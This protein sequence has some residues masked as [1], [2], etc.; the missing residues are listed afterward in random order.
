VL[1]RIG[2]SAR[3]LEITSQLTELL[4]REEVLWRQRSHV[5]WLAAGDKNTRFFH[6]CAS[7]LRKKW[8]TKL[9]KE[10]GSLESGE[11]ELDHMP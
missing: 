11:E 1:D 10:D 8:I 6:L 4:V 3:E 5:Q 7:Q 9:V 2:P